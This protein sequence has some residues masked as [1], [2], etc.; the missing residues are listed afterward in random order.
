M[1]TLADPAVRESVVARIANLSCD[2]HRRWGRMTAHQMICHLADSFRGPLGERHISPVTNV[3]LSPVIKW[4]ALYGPFLWPKGMPTRPEVAQGIGGTPPT[5]FNRD[6]AE[7]LMLL[8]A[9]QIRNPVSSGIRIRCLGAC[10]T[11]NGCAGG[12]CT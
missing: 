6:R 2:S 12:S 7:L 11:P 1:K 3:L 5:D 10:D 8:R 4:V 9:S